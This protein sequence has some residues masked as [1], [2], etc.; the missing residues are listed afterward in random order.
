MRWL[1]GAVLILMPSLAHAEADQ[2]RIS[3]V[4]DHDN[5]IDVFT[6]TDDPNHI[7]L[8][9]FSRDRLLEKV[10]SSSGS[11]FAGE[12]YEIAFETLSKIAITSQGVTYQCV[13]DSVE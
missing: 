6:S 11:K 8:S 9:A 12:G 3:Y 1:F 7:R 2:D 5:V 13:M 10:P 4:C